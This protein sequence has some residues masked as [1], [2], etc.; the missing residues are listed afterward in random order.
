MVNIDINGIT[1]LLG[2]LQEFKDMGKRDMCEQFKK[3]ASGC[4]TLLVSDPRE[5]LSP[6][7]ITITALTER[8]ASHASSK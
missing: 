8:I 5:L 4:R 7:E 2:T 3:L 6:P 1:G